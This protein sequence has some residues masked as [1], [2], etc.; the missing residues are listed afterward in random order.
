MPWQEVDAVD[1]RR[2]FVALACHSD[3]S[4]SEL[5]ARYQISR[6]TGYKWLTRYRQLGPKGLT[7]Q[8]RTPR[9][10]PARTPRE[11]EQL[12]VQCRAQYP[13]WG[14]RK[15]RKVLEN[16]GHKT[17]PSPST[18]TAVLRR[19]GCLT[20]TSAR[21]TPFVRF[22]HANPND[23]WQMDFKGHFPVGKGRC[24]PLTLLDDHSRYALCLYASGD[25][26]Y[27][28]VKGA[29]TA[30]FSR[31]GLPK[32]MTMDNGP[33]W[34]NGG[35]GKYSRLTVWLIEQ[36]IHVSH[37]TPYHPQTQGKDERFHRTLNA[38]LLQRRRWD[39]LATCQSHFD[40]WRQRYNTVRPHESL[41]M[42]VPSS[43]YRISRTRYQPVLAAYEYGPGD[44]VRKVSRDQVASFAHQKVLLGEAFVG[45]WVAFRPTISSEEFTVHY[46]H[47]Q[48]G[49]ISLAGVTGQ[50]NFIR[51]L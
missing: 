30:V 28:T 27:K 15:L 39:C 37:S 51:V 16:Q 38:E 34:G 17:L 24:H 19:H 31:Y 5:C 40:H 45:K 11:I 32:R 21:S 44:K 42:A 23:L 12:I 3:V 7:D 22:E 6:K 9:H 29:L 49:K 48:I 50:R 13:A 14:A 18:I 35:R 47:Q 25:Q 2:E 41:D 20:E 33:P 36:G 1:L 10:S 26:T 8:A 43:R 46:C 4:M